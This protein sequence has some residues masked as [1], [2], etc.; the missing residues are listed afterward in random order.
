[1]MVITMNKTIFR[2][3]AFTSLLA[4]SMTTTAQEF[5]E[6]SGDVQGVLQRFEGDWS[7]MDADRKT[8][9]IAG[10]E[11]WMQLDAN[12]CDAART[13]FNEWQRLAPETR[14][15]VTQQVRQFRDLSDTQRRQIRRAFENYQSLDNQQRQRLRELYQQMSAQQRR[16]LRQT[17][18]DRQPRA[19]QR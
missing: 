8:Q 10:A 17:L 1:M 18:Q 4:C 3:L 6:L 2:L 12:D 13:R 7:S 16:L 19:N 14:T 11:R 9:M 5:N 15:R